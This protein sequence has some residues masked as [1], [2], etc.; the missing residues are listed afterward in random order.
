MRMKHL[1]LR[2]E[3]HISTGPGGAA[4]RPIGYVG[5]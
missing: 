3:R 1:H 4:T 5:E 2:A